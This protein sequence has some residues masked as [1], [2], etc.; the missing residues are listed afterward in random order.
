MSALFIYG[1]SDPRTNEIRYVG[2]THNLIGRL[3]NHLRRK[4]ER[5]IKSKWIKDLKCLNLAPEI[6]ILEEVKNENWQE[7]EIFWIQYLKFIG[8]N[9][10]NSTA[11]GMGMRN[12]VPELSGRIKNSRKGLRYSEESRQKISDSKKGVKLS[13]HQR[14]AISE[15]RKGMKFSDSHRLNISIAQKKRMEAKRSEKV[16]INCSLRKLP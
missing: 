2:K 1:M 8:C 4:D 11:G 5:S 6:F 13:K 16:N 10:T 7:L 14:T 9:L 3:E 12:M 15:S